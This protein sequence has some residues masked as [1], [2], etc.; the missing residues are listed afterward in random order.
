MLLLCL[1]IGGCMRADYSYPEVD[2]SGGNLRDTVEYLTGIEPARNY[3]NIASLEKAAGFI[4][5]RFSDY[6]F[7]PGRQEFTAG[8]ET[9]FNITASAGPEGGEVFVVGAHYDVCGDTPGADDNA[10]AVAGLLEAA[11][12]IKQHEDQLACRVEFVAFT[13]EEPPFFST[14]SMGSYV[15]AKSLHDA[16]ADVKGMIALEMIGYFT[17]AKNSQRFPLGPMK[18][19]YPDKGNF[20]AVVSNY[21]SGSLKSQTAKHMKTAAINVRTLSAPSLLQGVDF[22]DHRSYW[23]F[24]YDA[25]MITDTA[26]YRNPNYHQTSDT[27]ETLSFDKTKEVVR[28]LFRALLNLR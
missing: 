3:R 21:K 5:E 17:D 12:L 28:G 6:G 19:F 10:S 20:I 4:S 14:E 1:F 13:L 25:V 24:G 26:F 2:V 7:S 9:Y 23:Q 8:G 27:I 22:S 16:G 15:H 11:R 18:L